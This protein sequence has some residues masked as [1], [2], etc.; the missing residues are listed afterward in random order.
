MWRLLVVAARLPWFLVSATMLAAWT[1]LYAAWSLVLLGLRAAL[2]PLAVFVALFRNQRPS[3]RW[4]WH[5]LDEPCA[6]IP[7]A[8]E[9][10]INWLLLLG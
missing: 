10:R 5:G 2:V 9:R 1:V 3:L 8:W 6:A 4:L 7:Q